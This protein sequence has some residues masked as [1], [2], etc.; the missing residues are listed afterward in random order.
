VSAYGPD[1][2]GAP[3]REAKLPKIIQVLSDAW[4]PYPAPAAGGIFVNGSVPF[5]LETYTRPIY[6]EGA[7]INTIVH[8][9]GH[10][11]W[12]DNVALSHWKDICLNECFA[13]YSVWLWN[14]SRGADLDAQY[15]AN[16]DHAGDWMNFPLYDMGPGH[17]FDGPGVYFKGV[18]FLHA[19]RRKLGDDAFF[20]A[21]QGIQADFAG[22][23][24]SMDG[25]RDELESRT[26]ADLTSFWAEW[27]LRTS[28]PSDAN[29]Y[30]G[31]LGD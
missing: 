5:S 20:S 29:L 9:N 11:W 13:S 30:P 21:L 14:E 10:Q 1:P 12:G 25:L 2:G 17:E 19:L 26:G 23:N 24:L 6:T 8:E 3:N 22:K 15:H 18:F 4:G 16:V 27:V 7:D 31:T 28:R